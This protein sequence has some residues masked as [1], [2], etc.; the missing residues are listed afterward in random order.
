MENVLVNGHFVLPLPKEL[1]SLPL[2][3]PP[4]PPPP[5]PPLSPPPL[6]P[7]PPPSPLR[8]DVIEDSD[9]RSQELLPYD[10]AVCRKTIPMIFLLCTS[11][12]GYCI[13]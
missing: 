13:F 4:P 12:Y 10:S 7:P 5:L 8:M 9:L 6:L 1:T 2:P 11:I 3:P